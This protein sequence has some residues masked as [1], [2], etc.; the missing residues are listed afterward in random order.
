MREMPIVGRRSNFPSGEITIFLQ[1]LGY[2]FDFPLV[3]KV[4]I[5]F[6]VR[7][8]NVALELSARLLRT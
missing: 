3:K 6:F 1:S 8:P 4:V 2:N 5:F 7:M